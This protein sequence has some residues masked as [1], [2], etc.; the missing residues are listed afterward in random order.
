MIRRVNTGHVS[1]ALV[2]ALLAGYFLRVAWEE[3]EWFRVIGVPV[4]MGLLLIC[5]GLALRRPRP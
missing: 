5:Q 1:G 3:W 4:S 2:L